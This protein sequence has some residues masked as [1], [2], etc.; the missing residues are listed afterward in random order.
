MRKLWQTTWINDVRLLIPLLPLLI[1]RHFAFGLHFGE[2]G[3][4]P[5]AAAFG[6]D[7]VEEDGGRFDVGVLRAPVGGE[8]ASEGG[9]QDGLAE[10]FEQRRNGLERN[11]SWR[12][13]YQ[14]RA[15]MLSTIFFRLRG[16]RN[17]VDA[18]AK[19]DLTLP[20]PSV[21]RSSRSFL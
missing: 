6:T 11:P 2:F 20:C 3:F 9:R 5:A 7:A 8:V 14:S 15:S 21:P 13:L 12:A 16:W 19:I 4:F 10:L 17:E 1:L 18:S